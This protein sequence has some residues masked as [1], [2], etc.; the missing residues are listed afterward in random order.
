M[1]VQEIKGLKGLSD[2]SNADYTIW[3]DAQIKAGKLTPTS[4]WSKMDRLYRNQQFVE[5]YGMD[6]FR[7]MNAAQRDNYHAALTTQKAVLDRF[8]DE[9]VNYVGLLD[10]EGLQELYGSV[11]PI[12][13]AEAKA[14]K[15]RD[16]YLRSMQEAAKW[17]PAAPGMGGMGINYPQQAKDMYN[18]ELK[19]RSEAIENILSR[20]N[21]RRANDSDINLWSDHIQ[22]SILNNTPLEIDGQEVNPIDYVD[23]RFREIGQGMS[24]TLHTSFGDII[25]ETG[26]SNTYRAFEETNHIQDMDIKDKT[27]FVALYDVLSTKY[28]DY[29]GKQVF[30]TMLQK[31]INEDQSGWEWFKNDVKNIVIGGVANLAN[32]VMG[33]EGF[34]I[35]LWHGEEAFQNFMKGYDE[36]GNL[37]G[38]WNNP[39]YWNGVDQYNVW[40][41]EEVERAHRNGGISPNTNVYAPGEEVDFFSWQ[42]A[43]EALRMSK[44][45][46]SE[47]LTAQVGGKAIKGTSKLMGGVYKGAAFDAAASSRASRIFERGI[48]RPALIAS[49]GVGISEAYGVGTYNSTLEENFA[50][51]DEALANRVEGMLQQ[52]LQDPNIIKMIEQQVAA[53]I[54]NLRSA[55]LEDG[56]NVTLPINEDAIRA[57]VYQDYA[58]YR[59]YQ[60]TE[61]GKQSQEYIDDTKEAYKTATDAYIVDAT[62]EELRMAATNAMWGQ[63]KFDRGTKE[64]LKGKNPLYKNV[65]SNTDGTLNKLGTGAKAWHHVKSIGTPLWDGFQSN[66]LDDVT[67]GFAEGFGMGEYNNYIAEKYNTEKRFGTGDGY[68]GNFMAGLDYATER[69]REAMSDKRS[70]YDGW[71]GLL[72]SAA[73]V[74][75]RISKSERPGITATGSTISTA[76]QYV[77]NYINNPILSGYYDAQSNVRETEA[78][79]DRFNAQLTRNREQ[80]EDIYNVI[81]TN[82]RIAAGDGQSAITAQDARVLGAI[83]MMSTI[84]AWANDP[85]LSQSTAVQ[86]YQQDME[87]ILG[88]KLTEEEQNTLITQFL[89]RNPNYM[90]NATVEERRE[91]VMDKIRSNV[92]RVNGYFQEYQEFKKQAADN[93]SNILPEEVVEH[94]A[95]AAFME[96][97]WRDRI[98]DMEEQISGSSVIDNYLDY[99]YA[100]RNPEFYGSF[101]NYENAVK[102]NEAQLAKVEARRTAAKEMIKLLKNKKKL[103][104]DDRMRIRALQ[105][106]LDAITRAS[107]KLY[108]PTITKDAFDNLRVLNAEEIIKSTPALRARMLFNKDMFSKEQQQEIER[109]INMLTDRDPYLLQMIQDIPVLEE[110]IDDSQLMRARFK[111]TKNTDA[112][113]MYLQKLVEQRDVN[114]TKM[115]KDVARKQVEGILDATQNDDELLNTVYDGRGISSKALSDYISN[116]PERKSSFTDNLVK[117][118]EFQ[119]GVYDVANQVIPETDDATRTALTTQL[120]AAFNLKTTVAESAEA[121][122]TAL[123]NAISDKGM[124]DIINQKI[125]E[126]LRQQSSTTEGEVIAPEKSED[127]DSAPSSAVEAAEL[128]EADLTTG[129]FKSLTPD[130]LAAADPQTFSPAKV[131]VQPQSD[132]VLPTNTQG[133]SMQGNWINAYDVKV[134]K[135]TGKQ[136]VK[137]GKAEGDSFNRWLQWTADNGIRYQDVVDFELAKILEHNPNM[138]IHMITINAQENATQDNLIGDAVM[139]AVEAIDAVKRIHNEEYGHY[140]TSRGKEYLIIGRAGVERTATDEQQNTYNNMYNDLKSEATAYFNE[141]GEE[142]FCVSDKYHTEVRYVNGGSITT[143][144]LGEQAATHD[145]T[146]MLGDAKRDPFGIKKID[147]LGWYVQVG[148]KAC[149]PFGLSSKVVREGRYYTPNNPANNRGAVFVMVPAGNGKF[150]P[151]KVTAALLT[152]IKDG[153]LKRQIQSSLQKV[154]SPTYNVR[155]EGIMELLKTLVLND[156]TNILIGTQDFNTVTIVNDS[157]KVS[158]DLATTPAEELIAAIMQIPFRINVNQSVFLDATKL[159]QYAE[160]GVF[161]TDAAVLGATGNNYSVYTCNTDGTPAKENAPVGNTDYTPSTT[162]VPSVVFNGNIARYRNGQ[163]VVEDIVN[164]TRTVTSPAEIQQ[165]NYSW[166]I[167]Q[168]GLTPVETDTKTGFNYYIIDSNPNH[169]IAVKKDNAGKVVVASEEA[170]RK[171]L[172]QAER[173]AKDKAAAAVLQAE[174]DA[175]ARRGQV[176]N[177]VE[178]EVTTPPVEI[179]NEAAAQKGQLFDLFEDETDTDQAPKVT[180]TKEK[181]VD[182]VTKTLLDLDMSGKSSTFAELFNSADHFEDIYNALVEKFGEENLPSDVSQYEAF[183]KEH[184]IPT[185]VSSAEALIDMIKNCR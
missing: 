52:E 116:T 174:N 129:E 94:V 75:P 1:A 76:M 105:L 60:L 29:L 184:N 3:R 97:N 42:T 72:G 33:I 84:T 59:R 163:W 126:L 151:V 68:L 138:P 182:D 71:I 156:N 171:L 165:L 122:K 66:Y 39:Q 178:D 164:G 35:A 159:K 12:A 111:D 144:L 83:D 125:E 100:P 2:L 62:L 158:Y 89:T 34:H 150:M 53:E 23:K 13:E 119:E 106:T 134:L 103:S 48:A 50:K 65:T 123:D 44:F 155:Q 157:Q 101:T 104:A 114:V 77:N 175:A 30:E 133:T 57:Q 8:G 169:P 16:D 27:K 130:Q 90:S 70:F 149:E 183:L 142:R 120:A 24:D 146:E 21:L 85:I 54:Q 121:L 177:L 140:I 117:A 64:Y 63:Y 173:K 92:E 9:G 58:T 141:H 109:A 136:V 40:S 96:K 47:Y 172:E 137:R 128:K 102:Y 4:S 86:Q 115:L 80:F 154:V 5:N 38:R 43:N 153:A 179:D 145:I 185:V 73:S 82:Q 135:E 93:Y 45:L 17:A 127:K 61:E 10:T 19:A 132:K 152:N 25:E 46:W 161:R 166:Q 170:A 56:F 7:S 78:T 95:R 6:A 112:A 88:N 69:G 162:E 124:L 28:G 143:A 31:Y 32:K 37:L 180:P 167:I 148:D 91:A 51:R 49:S 26:G 113:S 131:P 18:A 147:N 139:L 176:I 36:D 20:S 160:A 55:R 11:L 181:G 118:L 107:D 15:T 14:A 67:V 110:R 87:K 79:I 41:P 74:G 99:Y 22:E 98:A 168:Q 108:V 81:A